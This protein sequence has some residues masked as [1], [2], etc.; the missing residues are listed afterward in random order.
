[1][2][3]HGNMIDSVNDYFTDGILTPWLNRLSQTSCLSFINTTPD[4]C[5]HS[6]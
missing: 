1:L 2:L 4:E 6:W 3:A 5:F